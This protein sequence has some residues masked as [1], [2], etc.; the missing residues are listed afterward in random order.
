MAALHLL[1]GEALITRSS[2]LL[3]EGVEPLVLRRLIPSW[4]NFF[5]FRTNLLLLIYFEIKTMV[6]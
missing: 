4:V 6:I 3:T 5:C 1:D 2:S